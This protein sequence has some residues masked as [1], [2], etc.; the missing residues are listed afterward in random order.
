[1]KAKIE[2]S[3]VARKAEETAE[4]AAKAR[5]WR[6]KKK[7]TKAEKNAEKRKRKAEAAH[8]SD[9]R[10]ADSDSESDEPIRDKGANDNFDFGRV[11][12]GELAIGAPKRKRAKKETLLARALDQR[13]EIANAGG[14]ETVAGQ[15]VA[16]KFSWSAALARAGGEKVL[17]DPKLLS[18]SVRNEQK[19]KKKSTEKWQKREAFQKEQMADRQKKRKDNLKSRTKAKI[20]RKIDKREKK[21]NRPGFEGRSQGPINK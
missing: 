1:M 8:G 9:A 5:E 18:K 19:R 7:K 2:A 11:D 6:E 14:E 3:R 15:R 16:E 20:E 10:T 4:K 21:R 17:D 13:R 12:M